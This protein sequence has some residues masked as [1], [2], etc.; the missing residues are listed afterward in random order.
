MIQFVTRNPFIFIYGSPHKIL[1]IA[2][3]GASLR[4]VGSTREISRRFLHRQSR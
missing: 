2:R 4:E 3:T 1:A